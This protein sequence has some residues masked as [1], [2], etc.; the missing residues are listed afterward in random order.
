MGDARA[1]HLLLAAK[2]VRSMRNAGSAVGRLTLEE[3]QRH[4]VIGPEG[5]VGYSEGYGEEP[6]EI[7]RRRRRARHR[8]VTS[9]V[10]HGR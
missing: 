9:A 6:R 4:G 1:E 10:L 3:L 2:K 5:G 8:L 7:L